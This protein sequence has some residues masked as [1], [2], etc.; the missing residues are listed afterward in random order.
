MNIKEI[1]IVVP[2][3]NEEKRINL[4]FDKLYKY[5]NETNLNFEIIMINDGSFDNSYEI[6]SKK[7]T[8]FNTIFKT[9]FININCNKNKGKG[10][11]IKKGVEKASKNWIITMDIDLSV[12]LKEINTFFKN[13][14][15]NKYNVYYGS[16]SLKDSKVKTN[17]YRK[18]IG[19]IFSKLVL[20]LLKINIMDTQC[21]FKVY[22]NYYGKKI[23]NK[24]NDFGY[25]H[26]VEVL[27][28]CK[29]NKIDVLEFPVIWNHQIGS[30]INVFLDGLKMFI[31]LIHFVF[32]SKNKYKF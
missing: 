23:F 15:S 6:A 17:I 32:T 13:I 12:P 8:H 20:N 2:Y 3:F 1:S 19:I 24:I 18:F 14:Y 30:K 27:I 4:F 9:L 31:K 28:I 26:D 10:Y 22:S 11:A 25:T 21:G 29:K 7:I 5:L 16:R